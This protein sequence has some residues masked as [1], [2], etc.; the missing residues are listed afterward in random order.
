MLMSYEADTAERYTSHWT[1]YDSPEAVEWA[2]H[3]FGPIVTENFCVVPGPGATAEVPPVATP[4]RM[5]PPRVFDRTLM[6]N[7]SV[8]SLAKAFA[9]A[10]IAKQMGVSVATAT[11]YARA[12]DG[13]GDYWK[14]LAAAW[15]Y[16]GINGVGSDAEPERRKKK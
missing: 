6:K 10:W 16:D 5:L 7:E 9:V 8:I 15:F 2:Q 13:V 1:V 12:S 11:K 4:A 3:L 14:T